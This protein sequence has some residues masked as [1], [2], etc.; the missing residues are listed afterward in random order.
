[1]LVLT[2]ATLI[3]G[4]LYLRNTTGSWGNTGELEF[5]E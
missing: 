4:N 3:E 2:V 1:V 5:A